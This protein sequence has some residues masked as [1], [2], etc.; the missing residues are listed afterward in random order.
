MPIKRKRNNIKKTL[1][2]E[3][4]LKGLNTS[5]LKINTDGINTKE[6]KNSNKS[7]QTCYFYRV[8]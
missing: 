8:S 4:D 2:W 6:K 5:C 3:V 7:T 1:I